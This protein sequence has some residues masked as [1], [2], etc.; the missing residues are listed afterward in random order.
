MAVKKVGQDENKKRKATCRNCGAKLEFYQN[1]V[2]YVSLSSMC[3]S[4]GG[5]NAI[6]CPEC[7]REI[8]VK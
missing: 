3:E 7:K 5:Y 1:D 6:R 2:K 8:K 4:D